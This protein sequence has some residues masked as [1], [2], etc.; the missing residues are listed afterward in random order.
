M[1]ENPLY[2][3]EDLPVYARFKKPLETIRTFPPGGKQR[4]NGRLSV[5]C[6]LRSK[7]RVPVHTATDQQPWIG[8]LASVRPD[9]SRSHPRPWISGSGLA[10]CN[11]PKP[12]RA[13]LRLFQASRNR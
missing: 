8:T 2:L 3:Y 10:Q 9:P 5:S 13:R 11:R 6:H 7:I 1:N 12:H 4:L